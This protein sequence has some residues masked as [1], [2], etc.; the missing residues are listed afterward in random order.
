MNNPVKCPICGK[1]FYPYPSHAY[2]I[3]NK[4]WTRFVC[5]WSCLRKHEKEKEEYDKTHRKRKRA[6][7]V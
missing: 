3:K 1:T 4:G 5:T 6:Y 7:V 2:K